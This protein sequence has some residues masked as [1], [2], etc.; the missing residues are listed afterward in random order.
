MKSLLMSSAIAAL[1]AVTALTA[2]PAQAGKA[3]DTLVWVTNRE[4]NVPLVWWE[5]LI[6]VAAMQHHYFDTL[7][8]RDPDSFEYLPLL[9]ESWM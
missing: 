6:D 8:Y 2:L 5:N 4:A 1:T 3:D 7:V 9:A